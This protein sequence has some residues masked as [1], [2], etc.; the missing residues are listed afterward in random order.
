MRVRAKK[1]GLK[2]NEYGVFDR[3]TGAYIAGATEADVYQ[4][5]GKP[6]KSPDLR[7]K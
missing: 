1:M 4:A 6:Y 7:G 3:N 2:L 5:L